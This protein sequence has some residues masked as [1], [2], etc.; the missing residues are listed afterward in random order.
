MAVVLVILLDMTIAGDTTT[1]TTRHATVDAWTGM[2]T[3]VFARAAVGRPGGHAIAIATGTGTGTSTADRL[4]KSSLVPV[5]S[6]P[7]PLNR[8]FSTRPFGLSWPNW[9]FLLT[10]CNV[11]F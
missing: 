7:E 6:N 3:A 5:Y 2:T 4:F 10:Y 8:W 11:Y 9:T 1:G